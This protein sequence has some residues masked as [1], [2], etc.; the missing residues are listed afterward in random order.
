[1]RKFRET[2]SGRVF[3]KMIF[4]YEVATRAEIISMNE[5]YPLIKASYIKNEWPSYAST[6]DSSY[7]NSDK[8]FYYWLHFGKGCTEFY[9]NKNE[10]AEADLAEDED[11]YAK[12]IAFRNENYEIKLMDFYLNSKDALAVDYV[13]RD[14]GG[15]GG[16]DDIGNT[17]AYGVV[18]NKIMY[19]KNRDDEFVPTLVCTK[20]DGS[21]IRYVVEK[22]EVISIK[23]IKANQST[24]GGSS[25]SILPG[26]KALAPGDIISVETNERG[27]ATGIV[28]L[29]DYENKHDC[30]N[31]SNFRKERVSESITGRVARKHGNIAELSIISEDENNG[32]FININMPSNIIAFNVKE[33]T[34]QKATIND[35]L[36]N[37]LVV[38]C[39]ED[40]LKRT[41]IVYRE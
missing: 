23:S 22:E 1:M 36:V 26:K 16:S 11:M 19:T 9:V 17:H 24:Y 39:F 6:V 15:G 18:L 28:L 4:P 2:V 30:R 8:S 32:V 33:Q 14:A 40:L 7:F 3:L 29:Y 12:G 20:N 38:V 34:S 5:D 37:D 41:V 35:L 21:E 13:V 27:E 10:T 25:V 31:G